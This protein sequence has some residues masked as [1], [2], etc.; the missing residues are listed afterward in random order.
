MGKNVNRK[1]NESSHSPKSFRYR[2]RWFFCITLK[3]ATN[4]GLAFD[5]RWLNSSVVTSI[6]GLGNV[7]SIFLFDG[8]AAA[9]I[10]VQTSMALSIKYP[11]ES[12]MLV[13]RSMNAFRHCRYGWSFE[14]LTVEDGSEFKISFFTKFLSRFSF[15]SNAVV[16]NIVLI[17]SINSPHSFF[18]ESLHSSIDSILPSTRNRWLPLP[19]K[20]LSTNSSPWSC[21]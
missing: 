9:N 12:P 2:C 20:M 17:V 14:A 16:S 11:T 1:I 19:T 13:P 18:E 21:Y 10:G 8:L 6:W 5:P 15:L 4:S 3:Y 7:E